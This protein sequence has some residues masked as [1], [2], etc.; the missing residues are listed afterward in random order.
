MFVR[1]STIKAEPG[2]LDDGVAYIRE[3]VQPQVDRMPGSQG[4]AAWV[5]RSTDRVAV[6]ALWTDRAA[7]EDS[8]APV[9]G[10]RQDAA[11]RLGGEPTVEVFE[12]AVMHEVT[13]LAPGQWSRS[14]RFDVATAEIDRLV[15]HFETI[16]LPDIQKQAGLAAAVLMVDREGGKA[17]VVLTFDSR[18]ALDA[19]RTASEQRRNRAIQE[20]SSLTVTDV[21]DSEVVLAG[22]RRSDV[23]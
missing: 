21:T 23:S 1:I 17:L 16:A 22:F 2:R 14:T 18:E 8:A 3:K 5:D 9:G 7:L 10:L 12:S 20:I 6:A 4:L 13:P 11:K 15:Q 19:S